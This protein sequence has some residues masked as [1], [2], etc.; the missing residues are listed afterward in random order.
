MKRFVLTVITLSVALP[1]PGADSD[2]ARKGLIQQLMGV[3]DAKQLTSSALLHALGGMQ[4]YG[5]E[6]DVPG[7]YRA[8]TE[9]SNR[10]VRALRDR[11]IARIDL[12]KYTALLLS[13]I[14]SR[15]TDDEL[16]EAIV[17]YRSSA[18]RKSL[19]VFT[20]S[21]ELET[22]ALFLMKDDLLAASNELLEAEKPE[23]SGWKR[24]MA[25]LRTIATASE[26]Y[27][28]DENHYP[29]A[30]TM[31]DL[32][33][34]IAP[35]YIRT[36]PL[37]D[38]WGNEYAYIVSSDLQHYRIASAGSDGVFEVDSRYMAFGPELAAQHRDTTDP[39]DDLIYQDG[40]FVRNPRAA[41]D[42]DH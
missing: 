12:E 22:E 23:I 26:A 24:A 37:K 31:R 41:R 29:Q 11:M 13:P 38:P 19:E 25:D 10:N 6:Q 3:V 42:D 32:D 1:L 14:F 28:T 17:F 21:A 35:T 20:R 15:L 18:G 9:T 27:A 34:I 30:A 33:A 4:A 39:K 36:T 40:E 2:A 16:K 8:E 7:Q 5:S